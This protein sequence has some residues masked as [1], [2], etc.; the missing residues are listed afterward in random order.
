MSFIKTEAVNSLFDGDI[1]VSRVATGKDYEYKTCDNEFHIVKYEP[2]GLFALNPRPASECISVIYPESYEPYQF[3]KLGKILNF[4]R[5]FVQ[6]LKIKS[7]KRLVS[8]TAKILDIGCGNGALLKIMSE[9]PGVSWELHGNDIYLPTAHEMEQKGIV[10]HKYSLEKIPQSKYFDLIILNQVIEHFDNP[11]KILSDC[12]RLLTD[13]GL[14][15][16]ET[17]STDGLDRKLFDGAWGGYHF[18][19]HF[20]LFNEDNI[21]TLLNESGFDVIKIEYLVSPAFWTQSLHHIFY[22]NG[23]FRFARIFHLKNIFLTA[24]VVILDKIFLV[25]G[26]KTSNMRIVC[27][28]KNNDF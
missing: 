11:R 27:R 4:A 2:S 7:I 5:K 6:K 1:S 10:A 12:Q 16:I 19:R 13:K 20:Y 8:P 14:L 18:P 22:R 24:F 25:S 17:P 15:F 26:I 28:L 3:E 23:L 9:E 21:K